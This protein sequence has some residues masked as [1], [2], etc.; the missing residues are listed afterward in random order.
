MTKQLEAAGFPGIRGQTGLGMWP[1]P[2]GIELQLFQPPACLVTAAVP[3]T[4]DVKNKG[5]VWPLGVDHVM[6]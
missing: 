1:D 4:L 5:L 6:T 3:S 2:D